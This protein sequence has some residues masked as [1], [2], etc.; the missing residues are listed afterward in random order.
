[1][2]THT[3]HCQPAGTRWALVAAAPGRSGFDPRQILGAPFPL[4][5]VDLG[6]RVAVYRCSCGQPGCGVIA[7]VIVPSPDGACVA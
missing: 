4:L 6:R 1:M 3:H 7:P 5:P 2:S